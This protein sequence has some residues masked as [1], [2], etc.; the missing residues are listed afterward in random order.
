MTGQTIYFKWSFKNSLKENPKPQ[1]H[2]QETHT[3]P[4]GVFPSHLYFYLVFILCGD[5]SNFKPDGVTT[6]S[7]SALVWRFVKNF[8]HINKCIIS[9]SLTQGCSPLSLEV[10]LFYTLNFTLMMVNRLQV[11]NAKKAGSI[12]HHFIMVLKREISIPR[13]GARSPNSHWWKTGFH[14]QNQSISSCSTGRDGRALNEP[15]PPCISNKEIVR[16]R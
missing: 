6:L 12:S 11:S 15:N 10:I 4:P 16:I 7:L 5:T 3:I 14:G 13:L 1:I 2:V 9:N 8:I